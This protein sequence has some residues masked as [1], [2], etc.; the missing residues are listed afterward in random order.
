MAVKDNK[1]HSIQFLRF[2]AATLV[3]LFH[4][5]LA[6]S[7]RLSPEMAN[8]QH[9]YLFGFGAVGVHIFFV[10][11][12]YIMVLTNSRQDKPFSARQFYRKRIIRIYPIYWLIA[13]LY[14]L[15]NFVMGTP[16]DL[17]PY[18]LVSALL[19]LPEQ[20]PLIIGPAWTLAYEMYFYIMFGIAMMFGLLRG[21][22]ILTA[23]FGL[24]IILGFFAK[25]EDPALA[26]ATNSLLAEFLAGVW[27][28]WITRNR[29]FPR[30]AGIA[31]VLASI[32]LFLAGIYAGYESIPSALIWGVP[33][34]LLIF[35]AIVLERH[36]HPAIVVRLSRLGDSSY[37]LY[38]IHILLITGLISLSKS[39]ELG[40]VPILLMTVVYTG[41]AIIL[42]HVFHVV[43][44]APM[45]R[46]LT[47]WTNFQGKSEMVPLK[48]SGQ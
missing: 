18:A 35:G 1:V 25:P 11:S 23:F 6:L 22:L 8:E 47:Q 48:R 13:A 19:L 21:L 28:A 17:S 20:A 41:I 39:L 31:A 10:I 14:L 42:S 4:A 38:L 37:T 33:S 43:I 5:H 34:A 12:G 15:A 36:Y 44:E 2:V 32:L 29:E 24:S 26:L 7:T 9:L 30:A 45:T 16:Y 27:I 40:A 46:K 3:V